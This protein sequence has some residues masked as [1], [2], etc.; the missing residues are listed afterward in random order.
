MVR[1][2]CMWLQKRAR[3]GVE[4]A[5]REGQR[6]PGLQGHFYSRIPLWWAAA[7]G[8][9]AVVKLLLEKGTDLKSRKRPLFRPAEYK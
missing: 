7:N 3:G 4:A 6:R 1:R 5:A 8:H 9:E 2:C